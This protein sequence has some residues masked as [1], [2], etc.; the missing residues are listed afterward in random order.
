MSCGHEHLQESAYLLGEY[1]NVRHD[2]LVEHFRT[3]LMTSINR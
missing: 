2:T 1:D 3:K